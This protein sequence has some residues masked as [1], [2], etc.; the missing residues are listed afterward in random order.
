[1]LLLAVLAG[2]TRSAP[3]PASPAPAPAP[4]LRPIAAVLA[5]GDASIP[6]FDHAIEYVRD[7][8]NARDVAGN[9]TQLLSAQHRRPA[10]E[11]LSALPTLEARL[12]ALVPPQGGSCL[13]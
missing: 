10:D 13:V 4:V 1:M 9:T 7:L 3:Q 5:A 6:V 12:E 2:C 8:L 11:E